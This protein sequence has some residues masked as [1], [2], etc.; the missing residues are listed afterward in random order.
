MSG[1]MRVPADGLVL[2]RF[3]ADEDVIGGLAFEDFGEF[4]LEG[5]GGT[6]TFGGSGFIG[7]GVGFLIVNPVAEIGVGEFLEH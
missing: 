2:E 4:R 7:L 1:V 5:L 6:E 3:P